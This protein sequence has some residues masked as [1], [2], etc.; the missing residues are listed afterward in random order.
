[1]GLSTFDE[2]KAA[3]ADWL[4]REDLSGRTGDFIALA[5]ARLNRLMA[6]S[7]LTARV[8]LEAGAGQAELAA[9]ADLRDALSLVRA[10]DGDGDGAAQ[11]FRAEAGRLVLAPP[12]ETPVRLV[13]TYRAR[14]RLS[15]AA[16]ANPVL[17]EHPDLY[18]F[19]ALAEAAPFLRD[20]EMLAVFAARFDA[21][22][23]EARMRE[24]RI[25]A[26][27]PPRVDPALLALLD[28]RP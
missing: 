16:P 4:D 10:G 1:M 3:V 19:G 23:T 11:G 28:R 26:P 14:P 13:L 25:A 6:F 24:A 27:A 2:L 8:E 12:P 22:L 9:P 18:L 15:E 17:A 7:A 5:E 20:G 21:A